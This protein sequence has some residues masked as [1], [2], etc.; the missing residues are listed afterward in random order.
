M[1]IMD[2]RWLPWILLLLPLLFQGCLSNAQRIDRQAQHAGL[3]R[4]IVT[5]TVYRHVLYVSDG[6]SPELVVYL[7]G[8]GLPWGRDGQHAA[9]D[10]TTRNPLALKLLIASDAPGVYLS[11]P[12]YQELRD[13]GCTPQ[14]W[15]SGRYASDVVGS[16][17]AAIR[18][19]A[20]QRRSPPI[21]LVGYSGG[22]VLALLIAEQ[23]DHV[24][25]VITLGANLDTDAWTQHHGY[26]PLTDSLSP[27]SS[28]HLHAW[29]ELHLQ[30]GRDVVVPASTTDAYF[31][32]YPDAQRRTFADYD[33]VCCW[34][35]TWPTLFESLRKDGEA[36]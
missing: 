23:L 8:D 14:V 13:A 4:S 12:C 35:R 26:L 2:Y 6:P 31:L 19:I 29:P 7:D 30:G 34:V 1:R 27:A 10:P 17:A 9:S 3:T 20:A 28:T 16:M 25:K 36:E 21:V 11:R 15:T 32:R 18:R 5:G 24:A 22:G 33:H